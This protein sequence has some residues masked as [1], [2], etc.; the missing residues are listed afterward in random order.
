VPYLIDHYR[1]KSG[2]NSWQTRTRELP[3]RNML[4]DFGQVRGDLD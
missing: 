3:L 1:M 4:I 2:D